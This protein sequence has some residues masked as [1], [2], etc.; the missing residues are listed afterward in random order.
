MLEFLELKWSICDQFQDYL[1]YAPS[2][3]V[4]TDNNPLT[5]VLTSAK[6]NATGLC[7]V[8]ELAD[9]NFDIKYRPGKSHVDADT[10]SRL[11]L[12]FGEY[13][14]TCTE[15][16]GTDE[17]QAIACSAQVQVDGGSTWI[18]T[19]T[20]NPAVLTSD[21]TLFKQSHLPQ[22]QQVDITAAQDRV[23]GRVLSY[24]KSGKKPTSTETFAELPATKQLLF[25][26]KKLEV[27]S[28]NILRH[29]SGPYK[30]I[31]L[32]RKVHQLIYKELDEEM[33]HLGA[34]KVTNLARQHFYW[35]HM[36]TDI[37][38]YISKVCCCLKQRVSA[39]KPRAH[40]QPITTS[41]P[42][43]LVSIDF[44]HLERSNGGYEYILVIII[45]H[46]THY[47]QAYATHNK[48]AKTVADKLYDDFILHFGFPNKIRHYQGG[49]CENNLFS[50][51]QQICNIQHSRTTPYHPQ[52]NGQCKWFNRTLLYMLRTLPESYKSNWKGHL[53]KVVH[54]YNCTKTEATGYSPFFLLFG[55]HPRLPIGLLFNINSSFHSQSYPQYVSYWGSATKQAYQLAAKHSHSSGEK[56]KGY[57]DQKIWHS[58]LQ[59]GDRALV[60]NL[61]EWGGPGKLRSHWEDSIYIVV[62]Q[63]RPDS[64]VYEVKPE[65]GNGPTRTL[66]RNLLFLCNTLPVETAHQQNVLAT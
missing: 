9:F 22:I 32:P 36:Q 53:N 18:T 21:S 24:L 55:R 12:D 51:L 62:N 6:L 50:T 27:G 42:F 20:D 40:L 49:E 28:D 46:F 15:E 48:S 45:D 59:I 5:Y 2:F 44:L 58:T 61:S 13:M 11:P 17:I 33:G 54:A 38:F 52:G 14:K 23:I 7:W 60:R 16:V 34:E 26:W 35:P 57:Y 4:Y 47:T 66:H 63:K 64:L 8:G 56:A 29:I 25:E 3:R 1:Y 43:E 30:Q 31:V 39:L 19:L 65:A 10:F 41:S 37:E